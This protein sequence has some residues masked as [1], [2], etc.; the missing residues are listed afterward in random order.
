LQ[1]VQ[2]YGAKELLMSRWLSSQTADLLN[3]YLINPE[4]L[5]G[6][7]EQ[8]QSQWGL[9]ASASSSYL[10]SV[11]SQTVWVIGQIINS[12]LNI[13][14]VITISI[15]CSIE[16]HHIINLISKRAGSNKQLIDIKITKIYTKL[17]YRLKTQFML[18]LYIGIIV[19]IALWILDILGFVVPDKWSLAL[20]SWITE[21]IPYIGPL[22]WS[23]PALL[24]VGTE[25]GIRWVLAIIITFFLIQWT[26]NNILIPYVMNKALGI[27]P[28]FIFISMIIWATV[29]GFVGIILAIPL[30]AIITILIDD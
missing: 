30:A 1:Q 8:L 19:Y 10:S 6:L 21:F 18:C 23:I 11:G 12:V 27:S 5:K 17:W 29:L 24:V 28:L 9:I 3:Q 22:L 13:I 14:L 20:I 2:L 4:N 7:Q 26:E 16:K 25:N 15:L